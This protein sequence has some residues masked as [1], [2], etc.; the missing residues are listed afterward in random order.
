MPLKVLDSPFREITDPV[1]DYVRSVRRGSPRDLVTV[2]IPEYVVGP[3]VGAPPAQPERAAAQGPAAVH[4]R[5][6]G[7][8]RA[9][10]AEELGRGSPTGPRAPRPVRPAAATLGRGGG[11]S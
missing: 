8:Q 9:V 11:L 3:L 2:L 10:A 5:R 6:D 7:H 4:P 1:I